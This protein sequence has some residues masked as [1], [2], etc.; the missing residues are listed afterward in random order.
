MSWDELPCEPFSDDEKWPLRR[1][2]QIDRLADFVGASYRARRLLNC[3]H[4]RD[5]SMI[6]R[7]QNKIGRLTWNKT[8]MM[9]A[10]W[11]PVCMAKDIPGPHTSSQV[12][13]RTLSGEP[14]QSCRELVPM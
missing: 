11:S 1:E 9:L 13:R 3:G 5:F 10:V 14:S 7:S 4:L 6:D 2:K 8:R 12:F